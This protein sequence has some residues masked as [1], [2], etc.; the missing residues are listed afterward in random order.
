MDASLPQPEEGTV[1]Q[2]GLGPTRWLPVLR[3]VPGLRECQ[4]VTFQ[5]LSCY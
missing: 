3:P 4:V 5:Y 2:W 1:G